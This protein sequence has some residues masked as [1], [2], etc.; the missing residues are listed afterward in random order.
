MSDFSSLIGCPYVCMCVYICVCVWER[1]FLDHASSDRKKKRYLDCRKFFI[2]FNI[3]LNYFWLI[4]LKNK[5]STESILFFFTNFTSIVNTLHLTK[6][7]INFYRYP[8]NKHKIW[9]LWA[10]WNCITNSISKKNFK[11]F[12]SSFSVKNYFFKNILF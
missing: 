6:L 12:E 8:V 1:D 2:F 5:K 7:L 9:N 3:V 11:I 10:V 4:W